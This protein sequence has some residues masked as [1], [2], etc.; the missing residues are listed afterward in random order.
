MIARYLEYIVALARERHFARAAA[1]CNVTQSTLSTGIKQLEESLGVLIVE[2]RQRFVGLT[3]EGERVL[4]WARRILADYRGLEQ[5]LTETREGLVGEL[6]IGG[7]PV[8]LPALGLL[9]ARFAAKHPRARFQIVSQTSREIQRGLDEF[10]IDVGVTYLDNDPLSRVRTVELY[11][12]R[13]VLI[14]HRT[15]SLG[16][17]KSA[18]WAEAATL[19]LCLLTPSMQN[20][21]ILDS[22]FHQAGVDVRTVMETNSLV[23]LWSHVRFGP[24]STVVPHTFL[25]M[26]GEPAHLVA[27]PLTDPEGTHAVGLV[28]SFRDPLTP[29]THALLTFSADVSLGEDIDG[30]TDATWRPRGREHR[31]DRRRQSMQ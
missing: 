12:E 23:T 1:A 26:L 14:T 18:T 11:R 17:R 29:L 25:L 16:T 21:R 15:D 5:E 22:Y 8:G 6:R 30:H 13:Y 4:A 28:A 9:T 7:I 19:P 24:W 2:R 20:R 3:P 27:I 31:T 10:S